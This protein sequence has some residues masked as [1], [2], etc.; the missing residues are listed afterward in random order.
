M[1]ASCPSISS[2]LS[3]FFSIASTICLAAF[4]LSRASVTIREASFALSRASFTMS[5]K[6]LIPIKPP[7]TR[8]TAI[9]V[10]H[11]VTVLAQSSNTSRLSSIRVAASFSAL[12]QQFTFQLIEAALNFDFRGG[13]NRW[14]RRCSSRLGFLTRP[15]P[16][17]RRDSLLHHPLLRH[18]LSEGHPRLRQKG[19]CQRRD[20][21]R[22]NPLARKSSH[23][24]TF[25]LTPP[26]SHIS[27]ST[28][29]GRRR[30]A[31]RAPSRG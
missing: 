7:M 3:R 1:I 2:A 17:L 29:P 22:Q 26:A 6:I 15:L 31:G 4:A 9:P 25:I 13:R 14:F 30:L 12:I 23:L 5:R 11:H 24:T 20:E 19:D 16:H 8:N 18:R 27:D 28:R 21:N 10:S